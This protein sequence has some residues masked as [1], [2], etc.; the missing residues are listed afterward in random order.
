MK[1]ILLIIITLV[2]VC[3]CTACT[4][5]ADTQTPSTTTNENTSTQNN[6]SDETMGKTLTLKIDD[7]Q[8][9][10]DWVS[11]NSFE[12]LK[13]LAKNGLTIKMHKYGG[14]EQVGSLK[15]TIVSSDTRITT[16]P[17]DICL[18]SSNQIVIF[19]GNNTWEYTKL[20]HIN[21]SENELTDLLDTKDVNITINLK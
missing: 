12:A 21:L 20:G 18:Y 13:E 5:Q 2:L 19:Y 10:V 9:D 6:G 4:N 11:N 1:R 14:F 3:T 8:V 7:T 16:N 15:E 17:G